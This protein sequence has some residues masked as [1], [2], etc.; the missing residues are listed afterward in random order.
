MNASAMPVAAISDA[1]STSTAKLP[2]G[3]TSDSAAMPAASSSMPAT[4]GVFA[5]SRSITRGATT[6][7]KTMIATVIGSSAAPPS[8]AP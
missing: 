6:T 5:P 7:I 4:I 3:R 2:S 1:G 8:N